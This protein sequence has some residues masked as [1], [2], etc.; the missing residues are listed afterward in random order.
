MPILSPALGVTVPDSPHATVVCLPTLAD[1]ESYER[2]EQRVWKHLHAIA[3]GLLG[4][5]KDW[6]AIEFLWLYV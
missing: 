6:N 5:C 3:A 4:I 2:K 1:V